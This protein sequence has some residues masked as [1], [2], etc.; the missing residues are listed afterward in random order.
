MQDVHHAQHGCTLLVH[1]SF[2]GHTSPNRQVLWIRQSTT[3]HAARTLPYSPSPRRCL[4]HVSHP[5]P[6]PMRP[7]TWIFPLPPPGPAPYKE[8]DALRDKVLQLHMASAASNPHQ[9]AQQTPHRHLAAAT[10]L[11][12]PM[13]HLPNAYRPCKPLPLPPSHYHVPS[14]CNRPA[15]SS[16]H[17]HDTLPQLSC[18][19]VSP[20]SRATEG[21]P[22]RPPRDP[23]SKTLHQAPSK[24]ISLPQ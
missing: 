12:F 7:A 1:G 3:A 16:S 17:R 4:R 9:A 21:L 6:T 20:L 10:R 23:S 8:P 2:T 19:Y 14:R 24:P 13:H 5:W 18:M 11:G 22:R 15:A